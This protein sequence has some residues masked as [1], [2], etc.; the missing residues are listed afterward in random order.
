ML[1]EVCGF[2]QRRDSVQIVDGMCL[3]TSL[4]SAF[5][6]ASKSEANQVTLWRKFRCECDI[7]PLAALLVGDFREQQ[8]FDCKVLMHNTTGFYWHRNTVHTERLHR[9]CRS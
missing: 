1:L 9:C 3:G 8:D 5:T 7:A 6:R 4:S 2:A